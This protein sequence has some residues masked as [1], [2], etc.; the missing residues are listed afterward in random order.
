[1][2]GSIDARVKDGKDCLNSLP[3]V[4][5]GELLR[6]V[7]GWKNCEKRINLVRAS[8]DGLTPPSRPDVSVGM[9]WWGNAL[10]KSEERN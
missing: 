3:F 4:S 1:V 9:R 7:G 8:L 5:N 2:N 6:K 10:K